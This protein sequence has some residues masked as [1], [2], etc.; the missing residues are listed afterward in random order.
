M[1]FDRSR[2]VLLAAAFLCL[3]AAPAAA[4]APR[5][6]ID[7]LYVGNSY[8]YFNNLP[9]LVE[10]ISAGLDGPFVR[11]AAH[12]HG[13]ATL[14]GHLE[15]GHLPAIL[16]RGPAAGGGWDRVVLHEQSTLGTRYDP[17]TG[18]LGSPEAFHA[19]ARELVA[20][21]RA[22]GA[23]PVLYMTWAKQPFPAQSETL[24][25]AYRSIGAEL[26][27][28]VAAVGEAWAEVL[29]ARPG[30]ALHISD[31]SHPNPAGS[32]LAACVIY[33]T[34]TGRSPVGA[35]REIAGAPW[36]MA[37]PVAASQPTVLV[38]LTAAD[39]EFLQRIAWKVAGAGARRSR[40][41]PFRVTRREATFEW[42]S[43]VPFPGHES[44][45]T[46][47]GRRPRHPGAPAPPRLRARG[48]GAGGRESAR[49]PARPAGR[50]GLPPHSAPS[51]E[52]RWRWSRLRK[53][54]G[55]SWVC[56]AIPSGCGVRMSRS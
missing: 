52:H 10:G 50:G 31:G 35:P 37:G 54:A 20:R 33:A 5:D 12:T 7:V 46:A 17:E 1:R 56:R 22:Q 39:A 16:S 14:R 8:T 32:Y 43:G 2:A 11:G 23:E 19:A 6:T 42:S 53:K 27:V 44:D 55:A 47:G 29:R 18:E 15:D 25:R 41:R 36:D 3:V 21:I 28:P 51:R 34:L 45:A 49:S 26:G 38:S 30:F 24:S 40:S 48:R 4:Q 9:A 13:G